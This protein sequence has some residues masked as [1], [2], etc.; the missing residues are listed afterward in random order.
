MSFCRAN[1][2]T[3]PH[4]QVTSPRSGSI[5]LTPFLTETQKTAE[6]TGLGKTHLPAAGECRHYLMVSVLVAL[7]HRELIVRWNSSK[8]LLRK[9]A[10][11]R[12]YGAQPFLPAPA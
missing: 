9:T 5:S 2:H 7:S 6:A 3:R 8:G 11:T 1:S 12:A 10:G 4:S